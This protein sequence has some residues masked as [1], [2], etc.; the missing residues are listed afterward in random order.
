[1]LAN[2][3]DIDLDSPLRVESVTAGTGG[4]VSLNAGAI[5]FT[6]VN[7]FTG[8]ATFTYRIADPGGLVS[9]PATVRVTVANAAP[10]AVDD[11]T[12]VPTGTSPITLNPLTNDTDSP[13]DTLIVQS[14]SLASGSGG[15]GV[16][17]FASTSVSFAPA[18]TFTIPAGSASRTVTVNYVVA[19]G[20]GGGALTDTGAIVITITNRP[21]TTGNDSATLDLFTAT[22]VGVNVLTN[23]G[24]PDGTI[25]GLTITG[26]TGFASPQSVT[27]S[28]GLVTY[29]HGSSTVPAGPVILTYFIR[30]PNLGE[31]S[32]TITI[33][34]TSSAPPPPTLPPP[35][36]G[37]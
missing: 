7:G 3:T 33:T 29:T 4:T 25:A 27:I 11:V 20:N 31:A 1:M 24:D 22:S 35:A 34:I 37:P 9:A 21:P 18:P 23:D 6:P 15:T 36:P 5:L 13:G 26:V 8:V 19:D 10:V 14:A 17:T 30:D 12:T 28:G 16:V 32:G 2:D